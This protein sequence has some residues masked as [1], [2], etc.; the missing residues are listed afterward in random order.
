LIRSKTKQ[1]K[2]DKDMVPNDRGKVH[3]DNNNDDDENSIVHGN[4][5][6]P[7]TLLHPS[8]NHDPISIY[9]TNGNTATNGNHNN[10]TTKNNNNNNRKEKNTTDKS[11]LYSTTDAIRQDAIPL[12]GPGTLLPRPVESLLSWCLAISCLSISGYHYMVQTVIRPSVMGMLQKCQSYSHSYHHPHGGSGRHGHG[13]GHDCPFPGR[14]LTAS[15]LSTNN[16]NTNRVVNFPCWL[17]LTTTS[18]REQDSHCPMERYQQLVAAILHVISTQRNGGGGATVKELKDLND[19]QLVSI[20]RSHVLL[21]RLATLALRPQPQQQHQKQSLPPT[22]TTTPT[23]TPK[24]AFGKSNGSIADDNDDSSSSSSPHMTWLGQ[25]LIRLWGQVLVLPPPFIHQPQPQPHSVVHHP[26]PDQPQSN[27]QPPSPSHSF[28]PFQISLIVPAYKEDGQHLLE[29]LTRAYASCTNPTAVQ[30]ILVHAGHCTLLEQEEEHVIVNYILQLQQKQQ[31]QDNSGSTSAR[32]W[33]QIIVRPFT[34]GGGRGPC[35]NFGASHAT[36]A[37]LTFLHSDTELPPHWDGSIVRG[38]KY[39]ATS[40]KTAVDVTVDGTDEKDGQS[41]G[42][43]YRFAR[44]TKGSRSGSGPSRRPI[45]CA[46]SFGIDTSPQGLN[47]GPYPPGIRA[48]ETTANWR[49]HLWNLPYGDQ[50]L[51]IPSNIF[52]YVGGFPDQCLMEDYELIG[53]L[54]QRVALLSKFALRPPPSPQQFSNSTSIFSLSKED[55]S[56][57]NN[58][59]SVVVESKPNCLNGSSDH[60]SRSLPA[61]VPSSS[62]SLLPQDEEDEEMVILDPPSSLCSP[63]RWQTFGVL[64]VTWTNS[65][66]V[67][68]CARGMS[69][70]D[71]FQLYYGRPAP[72]RHNEG[73][74]PWEEELDVLLAGQS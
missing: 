54:R 31:T 60:C 7:A 58:N 51:S 68:L 59:R 32:G 20:M 8:T 17:P 69:P 24:K 74:S 55:Q 52:L 53:L 12:G 44:R 67:N 39:D 46:F 65:K 28:Y 70:D 56:R 73:K 9:T 1:E 25:R 35:L 62:S 21:R 4:G 18:R 72:P 2:Q 34:A 63:R 33:G 49:T 43:R 6:N 37:I 19:S 13:H 45:A 23:T 61:V 15:S 66:C 5:H 71:L 64:Y 26:S 22:R 50:C 47:G 57:T 16:N 14:F 38:L 29:R 10:T 30:L 41:H 3:P 11:L 40:P 42:R 27:K 48:V 36:G